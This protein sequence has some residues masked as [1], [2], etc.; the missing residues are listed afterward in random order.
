MADSSGKNNPV[1]TGDAI[2]Y[3]CIKPYVRSVTDKGH[4]ETDQTQIRR[5]RTRRLIRNYSLLTG[6]YIRNRTKMKQDTWQP[7]NDKWSRPIDKDGI[8]LGQYGLIVSLSVQNSF[9]SAFLVV[10]SL[11]RY[12]S[13]YNFV[14]FDTDTTTLVVCRM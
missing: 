14:A 1:I 12:R 9:K 7:L 13:H 10:L 5:R 3:N 6:N 2:Q 8:F 11:P 4:R